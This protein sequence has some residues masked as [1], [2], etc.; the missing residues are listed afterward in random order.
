MTIDAKKKKFKDSDS[1]KPLATENS[2]FI[3][4]E[5]IS[6]VCVVQLYKINP[7]S[8]LDLI[9]LEMNPLFFVKNMLHSLISIRNSKNEEI[10]AL[11]QGEETSCDIN[12]SDDYHLVLIDEI[13]GKEQTTVPT[14]LYDKKK[15]KCFIEGC[16]KS[17]IYIK[18]E[19]KKFEN[20][21]NLAKYSK[22]SPSKEI[23]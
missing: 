9:V 6:L 19:E 16:S 10:K 23:K 15:L 14:K 3:I 8:K 12:P 21:K 4:D 22:T 13:T 20:N 17:S 2:E 7:K 1:E 18:S 5:N 11:K